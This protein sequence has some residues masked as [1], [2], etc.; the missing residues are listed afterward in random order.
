MICRTPAR[1]TATRNDSN[2]PRVASEDKT[3]V[4]SPAAGPDTP[5][6]LL[7][8]MPTMMPPTAP[9]IKP[10]KM[11]GRPLMFSTVVDASPTPRQRG[12][13]TRKTTILAGKSCFQEEKKEFNFL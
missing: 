12:S 6:L 8:S 1:T 9:A 4:I 11:F 2:E 3:M 7:L 5:I 13:A 10:E